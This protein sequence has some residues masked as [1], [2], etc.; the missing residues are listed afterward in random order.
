MSTVVE[1]PEVDVE[2]DED[3][4]SRE[5]EP[6]F[7]NRLPLTVSTYHRMVELGLLGEDPSCELI[8]GVIVAKMPKNP[9]HVLV[10][11]LINALFHRLV[12]PGF[13]ISLAHPVTIEAR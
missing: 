2:I 10:S 6:I 13:A 7:E 11:M 4:P 12:P 3:D 8:E 9:P 1:T 5:G